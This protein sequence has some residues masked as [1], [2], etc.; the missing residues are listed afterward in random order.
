MIDTEQSLTKRDAVF[1]LR[2]KTLRQRTLRTHQNHH[3]S[4]IPHFRAYRPTDS[5]TICPWVST[6][7]ELALIS[8]NKA[9]FLT[10]HILTGWTKTGLASL[11]LADSINDMPIAF[12][13]LSWSESKGMPNDTVE[14][15]HLVVAPERRYLYVAA[16]LLRTARYIAAQFGYDWVFGRIVPGNTRA[17]ALALFTD[18]VEVTNGYH[19]LANGFRWFQSRSRLSEALV[20]SPR[21]CSPLARADSELPGRIV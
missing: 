18:F 4:T 19:W 14:V 8:G 3:L 13:T 1:A 15:C 2:G 11:V 6:P 10:D 16:R 20:F 17:I 7:E 12:R 9:P 5:D 21:L